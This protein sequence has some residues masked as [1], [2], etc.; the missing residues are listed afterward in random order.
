MN[1]SEYII[2]DFI[3]IIL[4]PLIGIAIALILLVIYFIN[5]NKYKKQID[6]NKKNTEN[7]YV[8]YGICFGLC[9]G[10]AIGSA[11]TPTFGSAAISYGISFGMLFGVLI[12]LIPEIFKKKK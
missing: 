6:S 12:C 3:S 11:F 7:D 9:L 10:T 8:S 2:K 1:G 5:K 4:V